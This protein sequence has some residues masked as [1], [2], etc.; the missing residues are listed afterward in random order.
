M[1]NK[2]VK[3]TT[4]SIFRVTKFVVSQIRQTLMD[5]NIECIISV[6]D[7][8]FV[9]TT[10]SGQ[11][12]I[13]LERLLEIYFDFITNRNTFYFAEVIK[14]LKNESHSSDN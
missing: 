8:Y 4:K 12:F 2:I 1:K 6:V 9:I 13:Y 5:Y 3:K 14:E 11:T 7:K 10:N